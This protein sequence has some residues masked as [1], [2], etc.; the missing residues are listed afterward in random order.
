MKTP[1]GTTLQDDTYA[2]LRGW[3]TVGRFLPGERLKIR[4]VA[5][6]L[7]VGEMPVRS[8]LQRL[9]AEGALVNVPNCGVTVPQLSRAQ[10]DDV[11]QVRLMLEGEAAEKGAHRL[12]DA[13]RA[14]LR[15]LSEAMR[16]A[17]DKQD[18]KAYLD[19]NERF[20]LILYRACGSPLLLELI[21]TVWLQVGPVSN[22]L[23]EDPAFALRLNDAHEDVVAAA[24]QGD[25]AGVR[26][27]IERDLF[28]AAQQLR[29]VCNAAA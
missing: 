9:A 14:E 10:F 12:D 23:F 13:G 17:L 5:E 20:H 11:L 7:G 24:E 27:A 18:A 3:L 6:A 29:T 16:A 8:A 25:S 2:T 21:E 15:A 4:Q 22:R 28:Y 19:A 26:R 1:T